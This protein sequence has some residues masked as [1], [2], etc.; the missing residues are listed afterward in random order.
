MPTSPV[1][2]PGKREKLQRQKSGSWNPTS[3]TWEPSALNG[4]LQ[5]GPFPK[6]VLSHTRITWG[7]G[8]LGPGSARLRLASSYCPQAGPSRALVPTEAE[9]EEAS[10]VTAV[11]TQVKPEEHR[12]KGRT[13]THKPS[14]VIWGLPMFS[15]TSQGRRS[16]ISASS[17]PDAGKGKTMRLAWLSLAWGAGRLGPLSKTQFSQGK[18]ASICTGETGLA[19]DG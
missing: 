14:P 19:Q 9:Q 17:L 8:L 15:S 18:L 10:D 7:Y 2:R 3:C 16:R 13:L 1:P 6:L 5:G 11:H 12:P 4:P